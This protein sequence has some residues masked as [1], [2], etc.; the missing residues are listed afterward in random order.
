M[1]TIEKI[2]K[3]CDHDGSFIPIS[4]VKLLMHEYAE[5]FKW[6]YSKNCTCGEDDR[7]GETWCCNNCGL[8]TAKHTVEET[9]ICGN[10]RKYQGDTP[11]FI[12]LGVCNA[13]EYKYSKKET[14]ICD[15]PTNFKKKK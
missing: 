2:I 15:T 14:D 6:D 4:Q 10:C 1:K 12:G 7:F 11:E 5:Q 9:Q 3:G 8:P 13:G